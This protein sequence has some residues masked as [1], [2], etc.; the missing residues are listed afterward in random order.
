MKIF[1]FLLW[2]NLVFITCTGICSCVIYKRTWARLEIHSTLPLC[3]SREQTDWKIFWSSVVD[4]YTKIWIKFSR[5][6]ACKCF[7]TDELWRMRIKDAHFVAFRSDQF[8]V[9]SERPFNVLM[10][11][12]MTL[13]FYFVMELYNA[14]TFSIWIC[15]QVFIHQNGHL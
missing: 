9:I 1:L 5:A 15:Y 8:W 14:A 2:Y 13:N 11:Q 10:I 3:Y 4:H 12:R 6:I 7:P